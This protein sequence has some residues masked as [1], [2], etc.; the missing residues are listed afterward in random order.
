MRWT[1]FFFPLAHSHL[2]ER[3]VLLGEGGKRGG[4]QNKRRLHIY[5]AGKNATVIV[6]AQELRFIQ[7]E[8]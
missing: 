5:E 1:F 3:E 2:I 4:K 7:S 8:L 6:Q